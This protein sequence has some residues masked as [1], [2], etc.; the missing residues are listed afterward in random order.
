[1]YV[2]RCDAGMSYNGVLCQ[3]AR[4]SFSWNNGNSSNYTY[5]GSSS[6][7]DGD[8]NTDFL[9]LFDSNSSAS[10]IQPHLAA[11]YCADLVLHG[12]D[13]WYLPARNELNVIYE[14][15]VDAAP[16]NNSPDP[17]LDGFATS[18]DLYWSSS[19]NNNFFAWRQR[20]SDGNQGVNYKHSPHA[21]RCARR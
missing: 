18:G 14:G 16:N 17:L 1:M 6:D 11:Q 5:W 10:G 15:L 19:E 4:S 9:I 3:G 12:R 7:T 13:D 2:P 8:G 21:V 20:F